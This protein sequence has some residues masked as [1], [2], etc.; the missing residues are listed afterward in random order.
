MMVN[1]LYA[2]TNIIAKR[3]SAVKTIRKYTENTEIVLRR[4]I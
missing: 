1:K 2:E 4:V 3:I